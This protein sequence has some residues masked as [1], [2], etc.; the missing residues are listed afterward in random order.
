MVAIPASEY[1]TED[2]EVCFEKLKDPGDPPVP[3]AATVN[4][5]NDGVNDVYKKYFKPGYTTFCSRGHAFHWSCITG[6]M[7]RDPTKCPVCRAPITD[8][9]KELLK[10]R[11]D[12]DVNAMVHNMFD[13]FDNGPVTDA[14]TTD[15]FTII[16]N[17]A[18]L[19]AIFRLESEAWVVKEI[20]GLNFAQVARELG[21]E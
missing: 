7:R 14:F 16:E 19:K 21:V 13:D 9:R 15:A 17:A 6:I 4:L 18:A 3:T 5:F 1:E 2:C 10:N 8:D 20:N 11:L 12:R